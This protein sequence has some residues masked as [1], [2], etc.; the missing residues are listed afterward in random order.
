MPRCGMLAEVTSFLSRKVGDLGGSE[1]GYKR[2]ESR[3]YA[4][5]WANRAVRDFW[6]GHRGE[7]V[8]AAG[9]Q[10]GPGTH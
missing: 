7:L 1:A 4:R 9:G 3:G 2:D 6:V 8:T 5:A 10:H